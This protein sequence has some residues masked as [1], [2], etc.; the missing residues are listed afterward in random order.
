M[1]TENATAP[2]QTNVTA[3][4]VIPRDPA[5]GRQYF[6][7][8]T[9]TNIMNKR[10]L[11]DARLEGKKVRFTITTA[12]TAVL[13]K[14]K[15]NGEVVE[16][17]VEPGTPFEKVI[18]NVDANSSLAMA[19]KLNWKF[20]QDGIAAEKAGNYAA[21][22]E[23]FNTFLNKMQV[24]FSVPSTNPVLSQLGRQ[25]DIEGRVVKV[26]TPNGSLLTIDPA[27]IRVL[28]PV[29]LATSEFSFEGFLNEEKP[30]ENGAGSALKV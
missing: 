13:V 9:V 20:A 28:G 25:V 4:V 8:K 2:E 3:P 21:A 10:K 1:A 22:H 12:G 27:S 7:S 26:T 24:S 14:R 6:T 29:E 15:D 19:N 5:T 16:S 30:A 11:L 17:I 18:F 23:A